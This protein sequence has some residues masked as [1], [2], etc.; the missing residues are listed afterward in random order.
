MVGFK[1]NNL[2]FQRVAIGFKHNHATFYAK[3]D[4]PRRLREL[5]MFYYEDKC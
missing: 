2:A 4:K 1:M 3:R 5:I